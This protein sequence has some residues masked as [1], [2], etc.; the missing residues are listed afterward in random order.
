MTT[1][2]CAHCGVLFQA[3]PQVPHQMY[4]SAKI[5]QRARKQSWQQ[6]KLHNDAAYRAN[7]RDAQRA[8]LARHPDYWRDYRDT[9]PAYTERNRDR[10]RVKQPDQSAPKL[11]KMDMSGPLSG[12][13]QLRILTSHFLADR[14]FWIVEL[15][16]A[17]EQ[18]S[19][20]KDTCK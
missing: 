2:R 4:C 18:R 14:V 3:R 17:G 13:Y 6:E 5:C 15:V 8:W 1:K 7:Q 19:C 10:Q 11:A 9:H 16:P 20:K 12:I